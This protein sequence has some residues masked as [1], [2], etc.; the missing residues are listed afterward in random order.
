ML[1]RQRL[2]TSLMNTSRLPD[3]QQFGRKTKL[4]LNLDHILNLG[5]QLASGM[6]TDFIT[7]NSVYTYAKSE[8]TNSCLDTS[9]ISVPKLQFCKLNFL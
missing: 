1:A 9:S 5:W 7:V 6:S 2:Y 8:I 4:Q 3:C